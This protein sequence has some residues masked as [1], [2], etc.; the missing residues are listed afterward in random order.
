M[1]GGGWSKSKKKIPQEIINK[2][3][4]SYGFWPKKIYVQGG[5]KNI[6]TL[7]VQKNI[8]HLLKNQAGFFVFDKFTWRRIW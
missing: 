5:K 2:N 7:H 8:L 6:S 4:Y 3:I 1:G